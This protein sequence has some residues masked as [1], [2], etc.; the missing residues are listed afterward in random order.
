MESRKEARR[1]DRR[2]RCRQEI[3]EAWI[4]GS[5]GGGAGGVGEGRGNLPVAFHSCARR[6]SKMMPSFLAFAKRK[7]S[8]IHKDGWWGSPWEEQVLGRECMDGV[9]NTVFMKS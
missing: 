3:P 2:L 6:E 8:C 5:G 1:P 7:L 4:R 9:M